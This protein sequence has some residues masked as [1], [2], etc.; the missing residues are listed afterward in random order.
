MSEEKKPVTPPVASVRVTLNLPYNLYEALKRKCEEVGLDFS[1][2]VAKAV[3]E[4]I[5]K[6][7]KRGAR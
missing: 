5:E 3:V 2:C 6:E 7:M 4:V 1:T